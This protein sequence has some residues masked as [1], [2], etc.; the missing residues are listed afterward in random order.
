MTLPPT[1]ACRRI[2]QLFLLL[3]SS[4]PNVA[5][6]ARDKLE[7]LLLKWR[8]KW[9]DIAAC[10]AIA[11]KDDER[12]ARE[13]STARDTTTAPGPVADDGSHINVLDLVL[14]LVE[15]HIDVTPGERVAIALWILHSYVFGRFVFTPRL[16]ALSPVRGCGKTILLIL[17]ELL[18]RDPYRDDNIT[19]ASIYHLLA[20]REYTLL[21]DEGDNLGEH[22]HDEDQ[23]R[24][25]G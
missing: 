16:T 3:K 1:N 12:R 19:P 7:R 2:R 25:D 23:R 10:I 14:R 6:N 4:N 17:L 15:L 11:N 22:V 18:C 5:A 13:A 24:R 8:L 9:E 21:L 20:T